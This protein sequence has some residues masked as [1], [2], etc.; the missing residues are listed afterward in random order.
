MRV[1]LWLVYKFAEYYIVPHEICPSSFKLKRG[2]LLL[3]AKYI[4]N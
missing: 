2:I 3:L 4:L 1:W